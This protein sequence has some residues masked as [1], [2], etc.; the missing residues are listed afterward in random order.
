MLPWREISSTLR[1]HSLQ[2]PS[3]WANATNDEFVGF[4][5]LLFRAPWQWNQREALGLTHT[6]SLLRKEQRTYEP[7]CE[8]LCRE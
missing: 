6:L 3:L 7:V 2:H 1:Y 4:S 8:C 5:N